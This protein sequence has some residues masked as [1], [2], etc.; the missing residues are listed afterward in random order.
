MAW[1]DSYEYVAEYPSFVRAPIRELTSFL[2]GERPGRRNLDST[3]FAFS[4]SRDS[5]LG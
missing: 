5:F 3:S 4:A 2:R 1:I